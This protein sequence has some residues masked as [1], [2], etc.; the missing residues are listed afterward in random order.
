MWATSTGD[1]DQSGDCISPSV[2]RPRTRTYAVLSHATV[3]GPPPRVR[4][5]FRGNDLGPPPPRR[6]AASSSARPHQSAVSP[7]SASA[8]DPSCHSAPRPSRGVRR[9]VTL[10]A[11]RRAAPRVRRLP[12]AAPDPGQLLKRDG[13]DHQSDRLRCFSGDHPARGSRARHGP[14]W[15]VGASKTLASGPPHEHM[16]RSPHPTIARR[17]GTRWP[18]SPAEQHREQPCGEITRIDAS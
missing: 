1:S 6:R 12:R 2:E 11:A 7:T 5:S 18:D 10:T 14:R 4:R 9:R 3:A 13:R 8:A 17:R 15:C 16:T